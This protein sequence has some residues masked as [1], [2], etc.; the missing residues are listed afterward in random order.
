MSFLLTTIFI[1]FDFIT[2]SFL[3]LK[4]HNFNSSVMRQGLYH[5]V[6]SLLTMCLGGAIDLAQKYIDLGYN[7]PVATG[8]CAYLILMEIGSILENIGKINPNIIPEQIKK[9][10]QKLNNT[11]K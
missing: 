8:I 3:A 7:I 9:R 6:G 1:V 5:K 4:E 10:F 11:D 2:G